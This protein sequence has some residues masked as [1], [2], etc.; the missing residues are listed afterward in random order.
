[1]GGAEVTGLDVVND[2]TIDATTPAGANG[3][4]DVV[5][6]T[7]YGDSGASG[8]AAFTYVG[9]TVTSLDPT[10][11]PAATAGTSVVITGTDLDPA[12]VVDFGGTPAVYTVN[13]AT[14]I[15][16]TAPVGDPGTVH[17][18]VTTPDG[19]SATTP[20]DEFTYVAAPSVTSLDPATGSAAGGTAVVITGTALTGA[21]AVTVGGAEVTGLDVVND[22]TIDATTPAGANGPADVVVT[23][24]Y[25]DSGAS[26]D[27]AFT[28]V[29]PTVTSLDP[30]TGPAATAGT[31]VVI[32]GTD[33]DPASVVDFGGTPA[34]Y[35]V[36]SATQITATAPVGDPG[37]VHVTVTTP[38]G[39]SATTPSDEFTYVAA[40]SV[41][42]LDPATGSAAGGTAV[43]ITGTALTG[44]TAVTVGG[45]EVTGLD[46]VNDTTI[47]ATTPAGANGPADVV[48]TTP[49][50]DSGASGDAAFTYVG[51]TVTSLDPTTGP[52]ATAGTSVV[53]TGTDLDPASV[54]DFGGTPAVYTVNSATQ[55]TATAPVGD[56]GTV[57]VT[58]TTPDGTSA[59]TPSDEFTYVAAPSVTSLDPATGSAAGG[60]AVV[61]TGTALTG[62][63]AVTVG[64]AEVTGLDV[65]NDTTIDA[66][67]PAGANGPA[68]VVVTTPYGDSGASGDA[69]FTYVGP[70]VTSL[71]PTTGPA[72]TAGTSV[73]ITGT[74]L[75]PASVV[76]FGGTP[77]VYTVNSATQITATAPVGDPGTVHVTVTTP[78]GTSATTP[79][80][81]FT[82]VAAPSVT[83]LDPATGSAAGGTA[84]VITGTALTGA[85]AVTV[86]GA[87]VTGLDVV[88]DTTIDATTPAGANGPADVVVTTPY[89]DSGASGDAAFTYVGPT[90]TSLDPTT[91]PAATAGTSVVITGTDLD[92][93][94][95]VDFGGTPAVY[96]VN[97]A[98]QITATAPVG[99]PGTVHVTVTTPDGTSATTPSDEF[100]YVA[101]PSVTSLDPATGSAA[102][103]TAVVITGTALTGATAVTVGGAEVTGLDV[104]NDT[105]ID[106]T[107]PAGANGPADVVVT[108][109][110]GDSGASG[111]AAFTYV[112]PTVT[113]LDPTTGPAATA[114]TSVV[115]TGTDLDPA[116]VVDF[117]GTPA[118][119]TVNSATQ[120]TATAPVGGPGTVH[121]TVTT[122]DGTSATTPSDE[123]TYVAAPSV[124]SL[125]PATG[126]AAGGT[127]VV[128]TGTALTGAT[129]V[130]VGGAEVTGLDVVNDTTIDAT[131]PA[132]AN[133][134]ADVVVTTPYGDSGASGDAAFTYVAVAPEVTSVSPD[135]GPALGGT[136]VTITGT[137]LT[138]ATAVTVGGTAVS[139]YTVHSNTTITATTPAGDP[140]AADVVV[141]TPHGNSGDSGT[142]DFTYVAAPLVTSVGPTTGPTVGG[143][144][145]TITGTHL[146]G[147]TAVT[148]GGMAVSSYTVHSNTTIT[149]TTPA[150]DAG[151]AD[152]VVTTPYGNSGDSGTGDFTYVSAPLVTS[153]SPTTGPTVGGTLVTITGTHLTGATAVMIG[154][155]PVSSFTVHSNTAI[156]ATTPAGD[157]GAADV[158]VT[159][160]YGNSGDSGTGDFTYVGGPV[161]TSVSPATGPLAGGT[162][163]TVHGTSFTNTTGVSFGGTPATF[164]Q[165]TATILTAVSPAGSEGAVDI[166][167][168]TAEGQSAT[169][170]ADLFAYVDAPV[171]ASISPSLGSTHGDSVVTVTGTGFTSDSTVSFGSKAAT[172]M[173]FVNTNSLTATSPAGTGVVD[174]TVTT[175]GGTS[176]TNNSDH[177]TYGSVPAVTGITPKSGPQVGSTVVSI[178]GTNFAE[179][180]TVDFGSKA[181]SSVTVKSDTS[182][183]ATSP[184]GPAGSVDVTVT[185]VYGTSAVGGAD[186]FTY[187]ANSV[188]TPPAAGGYWLASADGGIF[189]FGNAGFFGSTGALH[190][191][192]PIVGMASTPNGRGYWLVASDGGIF[193]FGNAGFYGSTGS[194]QLNQPIVGMAATPDG[195]G[196]WLVASDGGIFAFGDA[197]FYGSTGGMQLNRPIVGMAT[198]PNGKG[199]WL[200]ASDGGIFA[201]GDAGFYGSTGG[202]Q[203]NKPIVDMAST[204]NGKGYWLV[205]SD[206]GIF[207]FGNAGFYGS[208][209]GTP[210]NRPIVGMAPT[211][212]G[213]GYW[214]VASDGGIFAFGGAPF[215]GSAGGTQL[216][217]PVVAMKPTP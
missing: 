8:D 35:T 211:P 105:T 190:L 216:N 148:V 49:Y 50:G 86:G 72:A 146:T 97:S 129:A 194:M 41:T 80:D 73:V 68:D 30:T 197:G 59:T 215:F 112:G 212:N 186:N 116:S 5:V 140:G 111:D 162:R 113:S 133:G 3:P 93:A 33:L 142:G 214:L 67:T 125:D 183:V 2:T 43:V 37:T 92:P 99:D 106:A 196:Y 141:T 58:V 76:D 173:N 152:V 96:T 193:A 128:I 172:S 51:P 103:G 135:S 176:A 114:G 161:V 69:A 36:N 23:T 177:F 11:G 10:T 88:N 159:T 179:G 209:G 210:L 29:G 188:P 217:Q 47:D 15:T 189:A 187:D 90:V 6:T 163:V 123:F 192:Q 21:T 13:S 9:P 98:T 118:V 1:M 22:T 154:G 153:V 18:T 213:K 78:D 107:T 168:T 108:T 199:Y 201:F 64:G 180:S 71:D 115:I 12:S 169:G 4:A 200:V 91:G 61:I 166:T 134:P 178:S 52:A 81:E 85:T 7:P 70:T 56:P 77:A 34:V 46:V 149:A 167:V 207:A 124:T 42:S 155:A 54:V 165:T 26:G 185:T 156:T 74:D 82:Y 17:V 102:G 31:S 14:Q 25:G 57:H 60:T 94:S 184:S 170:R 63:T 143:T 132:G 195:K 182:I 20:S 109:P 53:I 150:G 117:G 137:D 139:S 175:V 181:A 144:L 120:I 95:V 28:Y 48:V 138:G 147:A 121:V 19:T 119:Y 157:A 32:T 66:T 84:V 158:V 40:P 79:S 89:G 104:V 171:V 87:E 110:Y 160:P 198:T 174:V 145:V 122:P 27:A 126:S 208:T 203:L 55:I 202:M 75:D 62:A 83:S 101:A 204:P 44:A 39:T 205:A 16:A 127:A 100:T 131:T 24:P 38:D 206:G 151:A 65:V 191:N 130:T 45:A 164:T 136:L